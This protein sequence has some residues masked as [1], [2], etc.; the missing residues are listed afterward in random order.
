MN[1]SL[2]FLQEVVSVVH[3]V[4]LIDSSS[5]GRFCRPFANITCLVFRYAE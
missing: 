5:L 3:K 2:F 4:L 1:L